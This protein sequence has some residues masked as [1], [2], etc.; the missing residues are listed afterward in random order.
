MG[1]GRVL[2]VGHVGIRTGDLERSIRFYRETLGLK[3]VVKTRFFNA[4]EVGDVHF[5]LM[6]GKPR[7]TVA[8]DFATDDVDALHDRLARA[9][10][11]CTKPR[12]DRMS[13]HRAFSFVDPDGHAITV[14]SAHTP[15]PQVD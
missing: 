2:G 15:M 12:D 9:G 5:C 8:F 3:H 13:G 6:P 7:K 14:Y 10:V 1:S 4:F 11:T